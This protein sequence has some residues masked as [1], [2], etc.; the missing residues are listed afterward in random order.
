MSLPQEV[1]LWTAHC[2]RIVSL[3]LV[4]QVAAGI[5]GIDLMDVRRANGGRTGNADVLAFG[6]SLLC[7]CSS[8]C[9]LRVI[10]RLIFLHTTST[11]LGS[12]KLA[13]GKADRSSG[14]LLVP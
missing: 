8:G 3:L 9:S 4:E 14:L 2:G 11:H 7:S 10:Q 5:E 13:D 6:I 1:R 12:H